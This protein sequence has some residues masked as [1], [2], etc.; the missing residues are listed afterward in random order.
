MA[1]TPI[2]R[3]TLRKMKAEEDAKKYNAQLDSTVE[4]IYRMTIENSKSTSETFYQFPI[5]G[6]GRLESTDDFYIKNMEI[7]LR[8]LQDLFPD[9]KIEEKT[10]SMGYGGKY[11]DVSTTNPSLLGPVRHISDRRF[12]IID[13]SYPEE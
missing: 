6:K 9:C 5:P 12:I 11:Y 1:L 7:I 8:K 10:L 2:S 13:W 4:Y 3:E